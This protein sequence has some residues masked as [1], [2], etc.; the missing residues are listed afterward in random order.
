MWLSVISGII[1]GIS[2]FGLMFID[3]KDIKMKWKTTFAVG[4]FMG[5]IIFFYSLATLLG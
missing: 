1:Y 2:M 3:Y 5:S 4:S